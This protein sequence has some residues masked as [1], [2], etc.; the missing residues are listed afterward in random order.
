MKKIFIAIL[1]LFS[2]PLNADNGFYLKLTDIQASG[3]ISQGIN[4]MFGGNPRRFKKYTYYIEDISTGDKYWRVENLQYFGIEY[5]VIK[6]LDNNY[7]SLPRYTFDFVKQFL[8][9]EGV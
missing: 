6:W 3:M 8:P 4:Q 9:E 5:N 7:P 1:L 2:I